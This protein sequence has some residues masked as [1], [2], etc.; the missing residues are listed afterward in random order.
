MRQFII[1]IGLAT[2]LSAGCSTVPFRK[3]SY[4][5]VEGVYPS[6]VRRQFALSLPSELKLLNTIVFKYV[7][8]KGFINYRKESEI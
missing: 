6:Q 4:V 8:T 3:V 2:L 1:I 5:S 7:I